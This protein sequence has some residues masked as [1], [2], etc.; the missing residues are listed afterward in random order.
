LFGACA[1]SLADISFGAPCQTPP[2]VFAG[3]R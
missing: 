3:L 2:N 1:T